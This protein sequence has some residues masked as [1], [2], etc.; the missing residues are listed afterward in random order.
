MTC[1]LSKLS[2]IQGEYKIP[3][4]IEC[5]PA[6]CVQTVTLLNESLKTQ[7]GLQKILGMQI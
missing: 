3:E 2:W 7:L 5:K 6:T 1:R 4:P